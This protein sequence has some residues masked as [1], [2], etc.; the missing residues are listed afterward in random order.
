MASPDVTGYV[1]AYGG[2]VN[3]AKV[4]AA[5]GAA[6]AWA[7][8]TL[9]LAADADLDLRADQLQA[10]YGYA[11]DVLK[12]PRAAF[13]YYGP[14]DQEGVQVAAGDIGRRWSGMLLYGARTAVPFA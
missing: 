12:L 10:V 11:G 8:A 5:V 3:D 14:D 4:I 9:G 13:G 7:R 1:A 2:A 6:T